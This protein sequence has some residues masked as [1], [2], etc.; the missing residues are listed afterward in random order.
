MCQKG[1]SMQILPRFL[2]SPV[3]AQEMTFVYHES[4][5]IEQHQDDVDRAF[6][7][8]FEEVAKLRS[9]Y[10]QLAANFQLTAYDN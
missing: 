8:V 7:I 5:D 6:G 10:A 2:A 9:L 3:T 1:S 4:G